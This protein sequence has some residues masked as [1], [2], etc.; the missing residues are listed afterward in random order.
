MAKARTRLSANSAS[1]LQRRRELSTNYGAAMSLASELALAHR[2]EVN[3]LR[4]QLAASCVKLSQHQTEL[5]D[6]QQA[7]LTLQTQLASSRSELAECLQTVSEV[8]EAPT[9][10]ACRSIPLAHSQPQVIRFGT[11]LASSPAELSGGSQ[12][13]LGPQTNL[14]VDSTQEVNQSISTLEQA[15]ID[16]DHGHLLL[17]DML[18][19]PTGLPLL[20]S[21]VRLLRTRAYCRNLRCGLHTSAF[22]DDRLSKRKEF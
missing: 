7:V 20:K 18:A 12:E 6:S 5:A 17:T 10:Q 13:V 14:A 15:A 4:L 3:Q 19:E 2:L 1:L 8:W 22:W 16:A 9:Q 11:H 21:T